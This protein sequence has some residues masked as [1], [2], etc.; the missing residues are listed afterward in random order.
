MICPT[1]A[2]PVGSH[3]AR[4]S[5]TGSISG[6]HAARYCAYKHQ[7]RLLEVFCLNAAVT[8]GFNTLNSRSTACMSGV[9]TA[10]PGHTRGFVLPVLPVLGVFGPSLLLILTALAVFRPLVLQRSQSSQCESAR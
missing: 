9:C 5:C 6:V 10:G 3:S 4:C 2:I 8:S 1:C 7:L